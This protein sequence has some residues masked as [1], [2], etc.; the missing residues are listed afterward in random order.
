MCGGRPAALTSAV[1]NDGVAEMAGFALLAVPSDCV[2]ETVDALSRDVVARRLVAVARSASR[3]G[4]QRV[5]VVRRGTSARKAFY[6]AFR[7]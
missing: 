1:G 4:L 7:G 3:A 6:D 2:A 5:P